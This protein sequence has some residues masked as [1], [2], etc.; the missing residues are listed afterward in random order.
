MA[1]WQNLRVE[2][3]VVVQAEQEETAASWDKHRAAQ[4]QQV[5]EAR[6]KLEAALQEGSATQEALQVLQL[7]AEQ[8]VHHLRLILS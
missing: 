2:K 5:A 3:L 6:G 1:V 4:D 8:Q 7:E